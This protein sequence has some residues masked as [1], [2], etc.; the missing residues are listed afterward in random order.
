MPKK[1]KKK[2]GGAAAAIPGDYPLGKNKELRA[3]AEIQEAEMHYHVLQR[4]LAARAQEAS[5]ALAKQ[6]VGERKRDALRSQLSSEYESSRS[7]QRD[8]SRQFK[9]RQQVLIDDVNQLEN[10]IGELRTEIETTKLQTKE[11]VARKDHAISVK[12]KTIDDLKD[13]MR[14]QSNEFDEMMT[15]ILER[16]SQEMPVAVRP[17]KLL[18][19][20][21]PIDT[22]LQQVNAEMQGT[23]PPAG[24]AVGER[25][26]VKISL[27]SLSSSMSTTLPSIV[28]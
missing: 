17:E 25:G 6:R 18:N 2:K 21:V 9:A 27:A 4:E 11:K 3:K 23:L 14:R 12:Q 20:G 19:A 10:S 26:G 1:G 22:A 28:Q 13:V 8:Y 7:V 15:E 16:F 5:I 24:G